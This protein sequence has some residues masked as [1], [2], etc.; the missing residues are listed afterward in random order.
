MRKIIILLLLFTIINLSFI[1]AG[2]S[3]DTPEAYWRFNE[4][5]GNALDSSNNSYILINN[6]GSIYVSGK[7]N[8]AIQVNKS[9]PTAFNRAG[10]STFA[11]L[12]NNFTIALWF[13][14]TS[15]GSGGTSLIFTER[16]A[17]RKGWEIG[18]SITN[19]TFFG[20]N[21]TL[22]LTST[23]ST[24]NNGFHRLVIVRE[25]TGTNQLKMYIDGVNEVNSTLSAGNSILNATSNLTLGNGGD[26]GTFI[27]DDFRIYNG[28]AWNIQ[29]I[30]NDYNSGNGR[31]VGYFIEN[32]ISFRLN[33]TVNT[34]S[35]YSINIT[36]NSSQFISISSNLI[37]DGISHPTTIIGTGDNKIISSSIITPFKDLTQN[38]TFFFRIT[39]GNGTASI[40]S[41]STSKIQLLINNLGIDDCSSQQIRLF[42][43]SLKDED[44]RGVIFGNITLAL[45]FTNSLG[46]QIQFIN[47]SNINV[48]SSSL[49]IQ[50]QP[51][52][53]IT[54]NGV[55]VYESPS[56]VKEFYNFQ[57]N[58]ISN[59]S[60]SQNISLFDLSTTRSQEFL[61]TVK[62]GNLI[63]IKNA[64]I[65]IA[66]KYQSLG[67]TDTVEIPIT[68][69]Q[70]NSLGHFVLNDET[71]TITVKKNNEILLLND[72]I[73]IFCDNV[74]Q[75]NCKIELISES[76][77]LRISNIINKFG[78]TYKGTY[79]P[80]NRQ[81]SF[82]YNSISGESKTVGL[83][84]TLYNSR[85][86]QSICFN[87]QTSVSTTMLCNVDNSV[88][89]GTAIVQIKVDGKTLLI[90]TF[91]IGGDNTAR[92]NNSRYFF[93]FLLVLTLPL[94]FSGSAIVALFSFVF[95]VIMS[96]MLFYVDGVTI[97]AGSSAILWLLISIFI[98]SYVISKN[99]GES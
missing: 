67:I 9:T 8:N 83:N 25:G 5:S 77:T 53:N 34:V 58:I 3:I 62:D 81:Y 17:S 49:C 92:L 31:E 60:L 30:I 16:T 88:I 75:G 69:N 4:G 72:N 19:K 90:N 33:T 57:S 18:C 85:L 40:T 99:R 43:F 26:T 21:S 44:T 41:D 50:N 35:N 1:S 39:L 63:P 65:I 91:S 68:D 66:R 61:I 48:S 79:N 78:L 93:A 54:L 6:N 10:N 24:V 42:N 36:Y 96:G 46:S 52:S 71:Y 2:N 95:G 32:N 28:Y 7:L 70:G 22:F 45:N 84:I 13:N 55:V 98:I 27:F 73:K 97:F 23:S 38:V 89:N 47:R 80:S 12:T 29:D 51:D 87:Q 20:F 86:N 15:C 37:Y 94:L 11:F 76:D 14:T 74:A 82:F 64:L 56:Y 59:N